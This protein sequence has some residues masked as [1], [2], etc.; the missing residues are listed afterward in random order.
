[1]LVE[2]KMRRTVPHTLNFILYEKE[3][4][5]NFKSYKEFWSDSY[6][7]VVIPSGNVFY[8]QKI[9]KLAI[10]TTYN[11]KYEFQ[12]FEDMFTLVRKED[13]TYLEI[14]DIISFS[15]KSKPIDEI[16]ELKEKIKNNQIKNK[17]AKAIRLPPLIYI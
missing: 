13:V 11:A 3:K 1:M 15:H 9:D 17:I 4:L 2:V 12:R 10:K 16:D 14:G 8:V 5:E 6:L 7:V